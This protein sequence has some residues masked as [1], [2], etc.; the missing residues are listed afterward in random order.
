M[1][2]GSV[3][4]SGGFRQSAEVEDLMMS[5]ERVVEYTELESEAH[6]ETQKRPPPDWPSK[7]P[8][9]FDRVSFSYGG[10]GAA[11]PES[12]V[13][14]QREGWYCGQNLRGRSTSTGF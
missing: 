5:V 7:G 3:C 1:D 6:W 8:V 10:D 11:E 13:P 9:T 14:T 2:A 12:N 4:S